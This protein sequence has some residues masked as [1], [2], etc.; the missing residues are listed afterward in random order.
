MKSTY[1]LLLGMIAGLIIGQIADNKSDDELEIYTLEN[2]YYLNGL[3]VTNEST[4]EVLEFKNKTELKEYISK[5]TADDNQAGY[6][7]LMRDEVFEK[8]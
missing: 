2:I 4:S 5:I 1:I 6:D 8:K 7:C 3:T